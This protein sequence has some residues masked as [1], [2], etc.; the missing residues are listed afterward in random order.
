MP[1]GRGAASLERGRQKGRGEKTSALSYEESNAAAVL[2]GLETRRAAQ[3][4]HCRQ[5]VAGN[6]G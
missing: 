5:A 4:I 6:R 1:V 2:E 3:R